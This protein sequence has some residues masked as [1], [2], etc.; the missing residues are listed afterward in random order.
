[1][2]SIVKRVPEKDLVDGRLTGWGNQLYVKGEPQHLRKGEF[3][4]FRVQNRIDGRAKVR[5][6]KYEDERATLDVGDKGPGWSIVLGKFEPTPS[7]ADT[8]RGLLRN[9]PRGTGYWYLEGEEL[10]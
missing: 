6:I 5:G 10:W 8:R 9:T 4:Y 3:V 2:S 7:G 1:M